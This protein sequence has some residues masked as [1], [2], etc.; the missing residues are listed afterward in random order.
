MSSAEGDFAPIPAGAHDDPRLFGLSFSARGFAF[1]LLS[2]ISHRG[3]FSGDPR[4][5]AAQ[6]RLVS[7]A[8]VRRALGE[9]VQCGAVSLYDAPIHGGATMRVGE[10][11]RYSSY[12]GLPA[13]R[14]YESK[15][16]ELGADPYPPRAGVSEKGWEGREELGQVVPLAPSEQKAKPRT[17]A[18]KA[19]KSETLLTAA[20]SGRRS[21]EATR[22]RTKDKD[23]SVGSP[24]RKRAVPPQGEVEQQATP[25]PVLTLVP[26]ERPPES[27]TVPVVAPLALPEPPKPKPSPPGQLSVPVEPEP[28]PELEHADAIARWE[29][30]RARRGAPAVS[31][32]DLLELARRTGAERFA[33]AVDD[34]CRAADQYWRGAL[35]CLA[36]RCDP[37]W[38]LGSSRRCATGDFAGPRSKREPRVETVAEPTVEAP[39][40]WLES[41]DHE[42][43]WARARD[44]LQELLEPWDWQTWISGLEGVGRCVEGLVLACP[45][46][47]HAAWVRE[48]YQPQIETVLGEAVR[49]VPYPLRE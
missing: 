38:R 36:V 4:A 46:G 37:S 16:D 17:T 44:R 20:K 24:A 18:P 35:K 43:V 42:A 5:L 19:D 13:N 3:R 23:Q 45:D 8:A 47:R 49:L 10:W 7:V 6:L 22:P 40:V 32:R 39:V 31:R 41:R 9:L 21:P 34:H 28:K 25:T 48:H 15:L 12:R 2:R 1:L 27:R 11:I 26:P 14:R 30:E 29:W 33:L